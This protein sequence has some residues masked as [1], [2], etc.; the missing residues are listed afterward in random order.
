MGF[1]VNVYFSGN[2]DEEVERYLLQGDAFRLHSYAYPDHAFKYLNLAN[3]MGKRARM[4]IDSGAFTSWSVGKP[5]VF[6][7]LMDYNDKLLATYGDSHDF[8]FIS[9][10]VIPGERGRRATQAELDAALD[11]SYQQFLV[12]QQ[13]YPRHNVLP[14]YHS[15]EDIKLRNAYMA[16]TDYLCLSMDQGMAEKTRVDWAKRHCIPGFRFHGL[17]ATGNR[18]VTQVDWFSVDSSSW[19]TVA[20]MGNLLWPTAAGGFRSIAVSK[21]SPQRFDAGGHLNTLTPQEREQVVQAI[22]SKGFDV[23]AMVDSYTERRRWNIYQW[24]NA[25]WRKKVAPV[26]DLWSLC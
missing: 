11:Q 5:V 7:D 9:L 21:E 8:L 3:E 26:D 13:H 12:M 18:M 19:L 22:T 15:G 1:D 20:N 25:P 14:V 4:I 24:L 17:A 6:R 10:D 16:L 23:D 2:V